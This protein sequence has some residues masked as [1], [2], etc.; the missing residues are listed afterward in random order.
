VIVQSTGDQVDLN[1]RPNL[2]RYSNDHSPLN[3]SNLCPEFDLGTAI[4]GSVSLVDSVSI[5]DSNCELTPDSLPAVLCGKLFTVHD[6]KSNWSVNDNYRYATSHCH[7]RYAIHCLHVLIGKMVLD[8]GSA[9]GRHQVIGNTNKNRC[10][11]CDLSVLGL[12]QHLCNAV[13][14]GSKHDRGSCSYYY[15]QLCLDDVLLPV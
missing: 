13:G 4:V 6:I 11:D 2:H 15:H 9:F 12:T 14:H 3:K 10:Q 1:L 5:S 8:F 7:N